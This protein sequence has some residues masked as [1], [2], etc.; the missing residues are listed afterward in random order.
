LSRS[1]GAKS[2]SLAEV[3]P[4]P[5]PEIIPLTPKGS[6]MRERLIKASASAFAKRGYE[7]TRV[8]D[9]V[10]IARTS[11]GNFYRHFRNKDEALIAVLRPLLDAVY[12]ASRRQGRS[13]PKLSEEE[14][15]DNMISYLTVYAQHRELLRVMRE[16]AAR[17]EQASFFS[18]WMTERLRFIKRTTAWLTGLQQAQELSAEID[19]ELAAETLGAL[20]EQIAYIK[21]GLAQSVP[22]PEVIKQI[23]LH[24]AGI[25]YRGTFGESRK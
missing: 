11:Y 13:S 8:E 12:Q 25:W 15:A 10:K 17:G 3:K 5:H 22:S 4:A 16:A 23:G 7:L 19:P 2:V 20:T 9:I 21:I 24:C 1:N 6:A 14:F 18:L